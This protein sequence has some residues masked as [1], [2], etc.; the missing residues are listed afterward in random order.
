M[1]SRIYPAKST[2]SHASCIYNLIITHTNLVHSLC[3]SH[4]Q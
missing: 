1:N 3:F 4:T 2:I